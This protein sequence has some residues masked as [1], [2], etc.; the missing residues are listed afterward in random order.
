M[1]CKGVQ[2]QKGDGSLVSIQER[3]AFFI[4]VANRSSAV[5]C[6]P[7][8]GL[9]R[10]SFVRA[11]EDTS[12][13][14]VSCALKYKNEQLSPG[15]TEPPLSCPALPGPAPPPARGLPRPRYVRVLDSTGYNRL[16]RESDIKESW[17]GRLFGNIIALNRSMAGFRQHGRRD[18][19][20]RCA[21]RNALAGN[22]LPSGSQRQKRE[23]G[24]NCRTQTCDINAFS[25]V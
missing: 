4:L 11:S 23:M 7:S 19:S 2:R 17:P 1:P 12:R 24:G 15:R 16:G 8:F 25:F 14:V 13:A 6:V 22:M 18:T 10:I 21:A 20:G 9:H 5:R 3:R